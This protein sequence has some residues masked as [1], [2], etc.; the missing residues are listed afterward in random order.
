VELTA[1]EITENNMADQILPEM[2]DITRQRDLAR[3]LLQKGM[4]DNLQG[5]MVS[6]RYVGAS[7][8]Q[9][10]ANIYSA[11]KG[12]ELATEADTKQA[13]LAEMLRAEGD[14]D[15]M[16][17]GQAVTPVAGV[18][19]KPEFI[20]QGQTALDDQGMPTMGYQAPVQA[21]AEKKPDYAAGMSI[22]RRSKDPETRQLAKMLMADQM[23]T[24]IVPE[25]GT[26]VRGSIG[27]AGETIKGTP[28]VSGELRDA[29]REA[30]LN[31]DNIDNWSAEDWARVRGIESR[32]NESKR[33]VVNIPSEGERKAGFMANILDRNILQMQ[34]ALGVDPK[35]V[36]PNVP[37]SIV[38][39]IA[40]ENVLS[41]TMTPSQRQIVEDSQLDVLDAALTLRT[42]A[43]Y[44]P[45]QLN[46]MRA[47]YF[48]VLG[49]T[50]QA[51]KAKQQRLETLLEGAYINSG[52]A[53]PPRVSR[54]L[55]SQNTSPV[56]NPQVNAPA[57][58]PAANAPK[59][60]GFEPKPIGN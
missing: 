28:K 30:K 16:A 8:W 56:I 26:V 60:L 55:A 19:A 48:P 40:G 35:A 3:M 2:Q 41:R 9:G 52:R 36:K 7:P 47:T 45:V 22:L 18:E 58:T 6:G 54:P 51:I 23:K 53:T 5:Q 37:A 17:Y 10:I 38:S 13:Q 46:A 42:G 27:G 21:V 24:L 43:A 57:N 32:V 44:T 31:L 33:T 29:A 59:F 20:P 34:N 4:T 11:Y 49:D 1:L 12:R 25:G 39:A 15:L 50:A 14:K